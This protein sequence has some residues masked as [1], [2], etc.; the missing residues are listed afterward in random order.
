MIERVEEYKGY[1]IQVI[2]EEYPNEF[3]PRKEYDNLGTMVCFHTRYALG[4]DHDYKTNDYSG[5]AELMA[6]V[7]EEEGPLAVVLPLF[8]Y[9]HSGITMSVWSNRFSAVDSQGWDW[10]QVGFIYLSVAKAKKEWG[11][12]NM[13]Q[14]RRDKVCDLLKAEV[15]VYDE[16]LRGEAYGYQVTDSEGNHV[17]SCCGFLGDP[18]ESGLLEQARETVDYA[19]N[20][21]DRSRVK[22]VLTLTFLYGKD[23][24]EGAI[25][26]SL[27]RAA[28]RLA[29]KALSFGD[30]NG[31][32]AEEWECDLT[33]SREFL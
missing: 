9:D 18:E 33:L 31:V 2:L 11:W 17:D 15:A 16:Y 29:N 25:T 7:E 22:A 23:E 13:S 6:A 32:K 4:D 27:N 5:W 12:K 19:A 1:T 30:G 10:G 21:R 8:L 24:C 20:R 3:N 28:N 26:Q 14:T